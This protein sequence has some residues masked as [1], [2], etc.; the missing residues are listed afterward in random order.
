MIGRGSE[1][2]RVGGEA[3]YA[4]RSSPRR[5]RRAKANNKDLGCN[6]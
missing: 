6:T 2:G 3:Y 1:W 5:Y 4:V